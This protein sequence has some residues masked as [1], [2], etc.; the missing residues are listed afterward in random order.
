MSTCTRNSNLVFCLAAA[1]EEKKKL[2]RLKLIAR[3]SLL[4]LNLNCLYCSFLITD[5]HWDLISLYISTVLTRY[6][7][8]L[9][10]ICGYFGMNIY[11]IQYWVEG[12]RMSHPGCLTRQCLSPRLAVLGRNFFPPGETFFS[13]WKH[14]HT[15]IIYTHSIHIL[16]FC[17]IFEC[18]FL[19]LIAL[20]DIVVPF[21]F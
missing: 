9:V 10:I 21:V 6:K 13:L 7:K 20:I 17:F 5:G 8:L 3:R 19:E 1:L 2:A 18:L 4:L 15:Y 11:G 16:T 14:T 12:K